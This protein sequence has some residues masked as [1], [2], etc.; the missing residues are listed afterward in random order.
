METF[1]KL[2]SVYAELEAACRN[3][4]R[5]DDPPNPCGQC[6]SCCL[7]SPGSKHSV[8]QVELA[9]ISARESPQASADFAAY[10]AR[11]LDEQ[12]ELRF[13][14]CPHYDLERRGCRIYSHRPYSCRIFGR[15]AVQ[16]SGLPRDCSFTQRV[17]YLELD[18]FE[19]QAPGAA[20]LN[21]IECEFRLLQGQELS[22]PVALPVN[23]EDPLDQATQAALAEDQPRALSC[24][25]EA[26]RRYG[27]SAYFFYNAGLVLALL[28]LHPEALEAFE[29]ALI[30]YP[31]NPEFLF[32]AGCM[33]M[34]V[35]HV[36]SARNYLD[37][38]LRL[39][40]SLGASQPPVAPT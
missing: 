23:S 3:Q 37:K 40:P 32:Y 13:P 7:A 9:Y 19:R 8:T 30:D 20:A 14:A 24:L 18:Q 17:N 22:T 34:L 16:G 31:E 11:A 5:P 27:K 35:G 29:K 36:A 6:R 15:F 39:K 1:R 26:A 33:S 38:A 25:Q 4:A 12:G 28:K 10:A 21:Q 2:E